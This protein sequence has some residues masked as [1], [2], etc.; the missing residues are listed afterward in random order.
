MP[1]EWDCYPRFAGYDCQLSAD[2]GVGRK[3]PRL[4]A[5]LA[6]NQEALVMRSVGRLASNTRRSSEHRNYSQLGALRLRGDAAVSRRAPDFLDVAALRKP[7]NQRMLAPL[8]HLQNL[9]LRLTVGTFGTIVGTPV[10]ALPGKGKRGDDECPD[11]E[12]SLGRF[13]LSF[14]RLH[15]FES[16][17]KGLLRI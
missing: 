5:V 11:C 2:S 14:Q 4:L 1:Q 13:F 6:R 10:S 8:H 12:N 17:H 16:L 3:L 9:Q 7:P 15:V